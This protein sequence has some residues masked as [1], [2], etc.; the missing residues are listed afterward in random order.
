MAGE[1]R[2]YFTSCKTS[3]I[4]TFD[5]VLLDVSTFQ[6]K[7][8]PLSLRST[9]WK[10]PLIASLS[11]MIFFAFIMFMQLALNQHLLVPEEASFFLYEY[12]YIKIWYVTLAC[13]P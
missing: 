13:C 10:A 7:N 11:A 3:R 4:G 12:G 1:K 9:D 5:E 6:N 8:K 2:H